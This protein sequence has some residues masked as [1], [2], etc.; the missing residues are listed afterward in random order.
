MNLKSKFAEFQH[1]CQQRVLDNEGVHC[2]AEWLLDGVGPGPQLSDRL[3]LHNLIANWS[4]LSEESSDQ[5]SQASLIKQELLFFRQSHTNVLDM[6]IPDD[7]MLPRFVVGETVAGISCRNGEFAKVANQD[8]IIRLHDGNLIV[9]RMLAGDSP[10]LYTLAFT[11]GETHPTHENVRLVAVAPI[12]W[13]RR[14]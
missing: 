10:G 8:C 5:Q 6:I 3:F 7:H 1:C 11:N 13:A 4:D 14:P 12:I 9:R 2:T